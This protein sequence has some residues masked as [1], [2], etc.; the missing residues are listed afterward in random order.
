MK[1]KKQDLSQKKKK[2]RQKDCVKWIE[3]YRLGTTQIAVGA[4]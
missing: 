3:S 1:K 4:W 2:V